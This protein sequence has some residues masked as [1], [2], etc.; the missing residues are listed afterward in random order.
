MQFNK[1]KKKNR[2]IISIN[3]SK[4][5][6]LYW[7]IVLIGCQ[8]FP[9][10]NITGST[11][12][13]YDFLSALLAIKYKISIN[14]FFTFITLILFVIAPTISTLYG[15]I[16]IGYPDNFFI[17]YR[18]EHQV[19]N[20]LKFNYYF[21]PIFQLLFMFLNFI[22]I[23]SIYQCKKIYENLHKIIK[24]VVIAGTTISIISLLSFW[25]I[26]LIKLFPSI[27]NGIRF[28]ENRNQGFSVEPGNYVLYQTWILLF[29]IYSKQFFS[30]LKWII[31]LGINTIS[32]ILTFSSGLSVLLGIIIFTPF[33]FKSTLKAK[34]IFIISIVI[35]ISLVIHLL[36]Q[37]DLYNAAYY[38]LYDKLS[39]FF[40]SPNHTIDSGAYRSYTTR[41]GFEIW[42]EYPIFG[43]GQGMSLYHMHNYDHLLQ[44]I[45]YGETLS[46]G[47]QPQNSYSIAFAEMGIL[48][49]GALIIFLTLITYKL[50]QHRN[51]NQL[52]KIFFIGTLFNLALLNSLYPLYSLYLWIFPVLS[53]GYCKYKYNL[54][55]N[56]PPKQY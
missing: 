14:D 7:I 22:V 23:M 12:K 5:S 21:F 49:G 24:A 32:L 51:Q 30:K 34:I 4:Y 33:I 35:I 10:L 25:G 13:I 46:P 37:Y 2:H 54:K 41:L 18:Y 11:F 3:T 44:I 19:L 29:T 53:Y 39:N 1:I 17:H 55:D 48:G 47:S 43:V 16:I 9:V 40:E 8:Q 45:Q 6:L 26:N 31:I 38:T 50:W 52:L 27:I 42:K 15:Y 20:S 56:N 36:K 28:Y